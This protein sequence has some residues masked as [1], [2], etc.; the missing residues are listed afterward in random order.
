MP[1]EPANS[2]EGAPGA[3]AA[4]FVPATSNSERYL[5]NRRGY[6]SHQ[7]ILDLVQ[8]DTKILDIGAGTGNLAQELRSRHRAQVTGVEYDP[9]AAAEMESRGFEVILGDITAAPTLDRIRARAPFD[10][11][12]FGDVLEHLADPQR[13]LLDLKPM[14]K[15][16]GGI[17]VSLP[18]VVSLR[19]RLAILSGRFDYA[20]TGIFDRTHLRYFTPRTARQLLVDSG[21]R[22]THAIPVG[23][24]T[25]R[26]GRRGVGLSRLSPG[27][28]ATQVVF[29]ASA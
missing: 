7:A 29:R 21:F 27:L 5:L 22:V 25:A 3:A 1:S 23:P 2:A 17:V 28:L 11:A 16:G 24:V 18:N 9:D 26:L 19:A 20:E 12:I 14:L 13:T 4:T 6:G 10:L 15:P 8:P